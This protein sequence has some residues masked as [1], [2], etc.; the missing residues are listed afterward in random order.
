M[1]SIRHAGRKDVARVDALDLLLDPPDGRMLCSPRRIRT[2]P[3]TMSSS[4]PAG[5]AEAWLVSDDDLGDILHQYGVAA[6][7]ASAWC[8]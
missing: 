3:C 8:C 7:L 6:D 4:C 5:D 2:M 1:R